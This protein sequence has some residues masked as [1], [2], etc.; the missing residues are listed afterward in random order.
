MEKC[1]VVEAWC[2]I[3]KPGTAKEDDL[4]KVL[5]KKEALLLDTT[6]EYAS[7][8]TAHGISYIFEDGRLL[9]ERIFWISIVVAGLSFR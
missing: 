6:C 4:C 2:K 9:W 5:M 8:S 1:K 7:K 3:P